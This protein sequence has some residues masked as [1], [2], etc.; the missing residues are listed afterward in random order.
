[1]AQAISL[2][3]VYEKLKVIEEKMITEQKLSEYLETIEII[4]NSDT[5][6]SIK[7]SRED[8]SK[9][10]IKKISSVKDI[11]DEL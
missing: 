7:K 1:M 10:R 5:M 3:Q 9:G 11:L 8:I 4:S 6:D 2:K